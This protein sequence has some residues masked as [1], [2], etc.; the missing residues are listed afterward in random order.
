MEYKYRER[1]RG[2]LKI[3]PNIVVLS[4]LLVIIAMVIFPTK[5]TGSISDVSTYA[6]DFLG[7]SEVKVELDSYYKDYAVTENTKLQVVAS[8][9]VPLPD[10]AKEHKLRYEDM[11]VIALEHYL[12]DVRNSPTA[13]YA[14]LYIYYADK[15]NVPWILMPAIGEAETFSCTHKSPQ[16]KTAPSAIQKNC[17]GIGGAGRNRV[18]YKTWEQSIESAVRLIS[19]SYGQGTISMT[20]IQRKYC[21]P[22][23]VDDVWAKRVMYYVNRI[24][25]Y[26]LI[27]GANPDEN[28]TL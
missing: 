9:I 25:E 2:I 6:M 23:C 1:I 8:D 17:W 24:N 18:V 16:N 10:K 28:V 22:G 21:G 15:Y 19:E 20:G 12:R 14:Y 13:D 27:Y 3:V 7:D 26:A 4:V 11:R 5:F